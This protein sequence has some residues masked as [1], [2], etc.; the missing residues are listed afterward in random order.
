MNILIDKNIT[1]AEEAFS[2]LGKVKLINGREISIKDLENID[3]LIVGSTTKVNKELLKDSDI[4]FV[5]TA[6]AGTDHI[7][8][9]YLNEKGIKFASAAGCNSWAVVEYVYAAIFYFYEKYSL[10]LQNKSI[11]IIGC[12]SIGSKIAEVAK[13]FNIELLINDPPLQRKTGDEKYKSL[14]EVLSADIITFHVP[15]NE[16][17]QDKTVH[18]LNEENINLIK[19]HALLINT[20]RGPV[21]EKEA[22]SKRLSQ[23]R[24]IFTVIDVWENEPNIDTELLN[25][26]ELATPH[27]AGYSFEGKVNGT[28]MI[29]NSLC[30]FLNTTPAWQ[31]KLPEIENNKVD[32]R[33]AWSPEQNLHQIINNIYPIWK[34]GVQ[35]R[36]LLEVK[37][38]EIA[39]T[40]DELRK[41]YKLRRE[42]TNYCVEETMV[43]QKEAA[44]VLRLNLI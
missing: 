11:G 44:E 19:P 16:S 18:L 27:I 13:V 8:T 23:K 40:F 28:K 35:M 15:L 32:I 12:G 43:L 6:T 36:K 21:I 26:I 22:L 17:G 25:I 30:E 39:N 37:K 4:K 20:S 3:V 14:E 42:F 33:R 2:N 7:D 29:Y 9:D 10:I 38:E 5:G 31:P 41:N 34:D 24:N 1:F